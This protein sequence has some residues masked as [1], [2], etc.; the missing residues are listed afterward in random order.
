MKI[1]LIILSVAVL[2]ANLCCAS[3]GNSLLDNYLEMALNYSPDLKSAARNV[4]ASMELLEAAR[5][6]LYPEL[7]GTAD[8][9]FT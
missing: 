7:S 4:S 1:Y 8:F 6:E 2:S 9:K 3:N 5:K